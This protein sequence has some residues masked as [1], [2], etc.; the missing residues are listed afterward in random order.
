MIIGML[1]SVF[2]IVAGQH[3]IKVAFDQLTTQ[4]PDLTQFKTDVL[5]GFKLFGALAG[6][7]FLL[8]G[9]GLIFMFYGLFKQIDSGHK[10]SE[11]LQHQKGGLKLMVALVIISYL[12]SALV[13]Y[14]YGRYRNFVNIF[15]RWLVYPI[16]AILIELPNMLA[17]YIIH[18]QTYKPVEEVK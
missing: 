11:T 4:N 6:T 16:L 12:I 5:R 8:I 7:Y 9:L 10:L 2:I 1:F 17:I 18:W 14:P 15:I 13:I 3:N